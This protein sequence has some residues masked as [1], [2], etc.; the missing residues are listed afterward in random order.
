[1]MSETGRALSRENF[2]LL[3]SPIR[4]ESPLQ[5][6]TPLSSIFAR[7]RLDAFIPELDEEIFVYDYGLKSEYEKI[8]REYI[9]RNDFKDINRMIKLLQKN[10]PCE[11][12]AQS[13]GKIDE[14]CL[15]AE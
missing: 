6:N 8:F 5:R 3:I 7:T 10:I 9:D 12:A 15:L 2:P 13:G 1:M 4:G 11:L 14:K